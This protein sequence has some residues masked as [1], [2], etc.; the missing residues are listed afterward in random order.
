METVTS[1]DGTPIAYERTG[2][3]PP[4]VL[5]HGTTADHTRW[6]PVLPPLEERFTVY[7]MDRRGRGES[8]DAAKYDLEREF[9]DVVA[10]VDSIDDPVVLLG[11]SYGAL[12]SLEASLRTDTLRALVL[13]EPPIP[14][15]DH[16][17]HDEDELARMK[18][19]LDDGED[20]RALILFLREVADIPSA[21]IDVLQSAP[22]WPTRVAAAHT[23]YRETEAPGNYEFEPARFEQMRTPTL[24]LS[25]GESPTWFRDATAALDAA[26]PDSRVVVLEGQEHVAMN[27]APDL[28]IET[29]LTFISELS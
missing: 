12:C 29:V 13:Y 19:M 18:A 22:N 4:L 28:F 10:V 23:A 26:L 6:E 7:A 27:T 2:S 5:V 1:A 17:L 11:H 3:G 21:Q 25:G 16:E 24:L 14:V 15:G 9:D 8:G 20:E